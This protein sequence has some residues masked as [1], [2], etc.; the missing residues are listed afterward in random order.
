MTSSHKQTRSSRLW[1]SIIHAKT[2][3]MTISNMSVLQRDRAC[4]YTKTIVIV[5]VL[6]SITAYWLY[7]QC[8]PKKGSGPHLVNSPSL[9]PRISCD[10]NAT[11]GRQMTTVDIKSE[12]SSS[13]VSAELRWS[14]CIILQNITEFRTTVKIAS[15][16]LIKQVVYR[17]EANRMD[18]FLT[19][20]LSLFEGGK[21]TRWIYAGCLVV[22]LLRSVFGIEK[23]TPWHPE[24]TLLL[25]RPTNS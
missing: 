16:C 5:E 1:Y 12:I 19:T 24:Y 14:H 13:H 2:W 8:M 23:S 3:E 9:Y 21:L 7:V 10:A 11:F 4:G 22:S 17:T 20:W 6:I 18:A 25:R 15:R